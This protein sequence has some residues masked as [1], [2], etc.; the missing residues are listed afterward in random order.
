MAAHPGVADHQVLDRGPL[1]VAEVER[2]GH[3]RRRLD[4]RERRAG[5]G[6]RSSPRRRARRRPRRASARRSRLRR[7]AACRPSG[8]SGHRWSVLSRT[9]TPARPADERVVV[10]PAGSVSVPWPVIAAG[11]V[12]G[13]LATRYRA[14]GVTARE[15]R[16]RRRIPRGSH[17]PALAS[18]RPDATLLG[19][20]REGGSVAR[21]VMPPS[22]GRSSARPAR[23]RP[24]AV[25][26]MMRSMCVRETRVVRGRHQRSARSHADG[27]R[28]GLV[29][30][31][32]RAAESG[33]P[34]R[35][36]HPID[37]AR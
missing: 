9:E 2:A 5:P 20:R 22:D 10:P 27:T 32:L 13:T 6:R 24:F 19:H 35:R 11:L 23:H 8:S 33:S 15:R 34:S 25:Q 4:D 28:V 12:S 17:R 31:C 7:R 18:G 30:A 29:G 1:G 26:L 36:G 14:S 3:V 16:S 37:R 21:A